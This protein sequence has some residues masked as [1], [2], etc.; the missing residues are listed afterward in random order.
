MAINIIFRD[1]EER[2]VPVRASKKVEAKHQV[3]LLLTYVT[4]EGEEDAVLLDS[5]QNMH[6]VCIE[7]RREGNNVHKIQVMLQRGYHAFSP[8]DPGD[9]LACRKVYQ[10]NGRKGQCRVRKRNVHICFNCC[11][12]MS[13]PE[14]LKQ[15]VQWC[16]KAGHQRIRYPEEGE[17]MEFK[18]GYKRSQ[19]PFV[20]FYD[21]E[22]LQSPTKAPCSCDDETLEYTYAPPEKQQAMEHDNYLRANWEKTRTRR[23]RKCPHKTKV[24]NRQVPFAYYIIVVDREGEVILS[25]DY[26]G[27]DAGG[28]FCDDILDLEEI[29]T[30]RMAD[31]R[32]MELTPED[33]RRANE[34]THCWLCEKYMGQDRVKDHDHLTGKFLGMAHNICNFRRRELKKIVAFSHNFSG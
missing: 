2:I 5:R 21:F 8:Q 12:A 26:V 28:N 33:L 11:N 4:A 6:Y 32:E 19:V 18:M 30:Q 27:P 34:Q 10:D 24:L 14:A 3:V 20:I 7:V 17:K 15:H 1:E 29:L 13:T 22:T 16:H 23:L 9:F 25:R 31:V